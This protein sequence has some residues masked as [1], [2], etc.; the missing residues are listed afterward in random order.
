MKE[1]GILSP[2]SEL[3]PPERVLVTFD[4]WESVPY[5]PCSLAVALL[6]MAYQ[7]ILLGH[8]IVN[9]LSN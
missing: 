5:L 9:L 7:E 4:S 1:Q 6:F 3:D 8:E 2:V